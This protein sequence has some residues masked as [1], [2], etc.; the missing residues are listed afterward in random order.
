[1]GNIRKALK[2]LINNN[3]LYINDNI[4]INDTNSAIKPEIS[5]ESICNNNSLE[6][7]VLIPVNHSSDCVV[8][9]FNENTCEFK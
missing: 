7:N 3:P 4:N 5:S 6:E 8:N 2:W 1:M 9:S